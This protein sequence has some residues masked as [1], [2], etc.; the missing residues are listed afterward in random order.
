LD[1]SDV[2]SEVGGVVVDRRTQDPLRGPD[3]ESA[4]ALR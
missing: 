3:I 2:K 1:L 4:E